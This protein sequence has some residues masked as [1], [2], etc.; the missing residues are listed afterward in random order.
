MAGKFFGTSKTPLS[1]SPKNLP[2]IRP[3]SRLALSTTVPSV[4]SLNRKF[5]GTP[6]K[7]MLTSF[8]IMQLFQESVERSESSKL[9][10]TN[11]LEELLFT[12]A[13]HECYLRMLFYLWWTLTLIKTILILAGNVKLIVSA[14]TF[15]TSSEVTKRLH[16]I[17]LL[18]FR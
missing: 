16:H 12:N 14:L 4:S 10:I 15:Q 18:L 13:F 2:E 8:F 11:T 5:L 6:A 7:W 1:A 9:I 3:P 17:N